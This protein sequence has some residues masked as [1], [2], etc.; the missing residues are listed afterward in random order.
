[1]AFRV[2]I[3][4]RGELDLQ[5]IVDWIRDRSPDGARCWWDAYIE[6]RSKLQ[7]APLTFARAPE[8]A[9]TDRDIRHL[10]FKTAHGKYYRL[11]FVVVEGEVQI[12]RVR[13]L[14]QPDLA[15][16]ELE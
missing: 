8:A 12:L 16:D 7:N 6:A 1:M 4:P 15:D 5:L 3:L 2:R 13:G 14:G 9:Q 10:L 11:L